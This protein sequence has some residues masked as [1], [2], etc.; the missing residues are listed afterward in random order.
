[1]L[2]IQEQAKTYKITKTLQA[3]KIMWLEIELKNLIKKTWI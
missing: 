1:M 2:K 3:V